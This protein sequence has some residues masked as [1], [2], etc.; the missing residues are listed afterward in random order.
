MLNNEAYS[1]GSITVYKIHTWIR[2]ISAIIFLLCVIPM[3]FVRWIVEEDIEAALIA[4]FILTMPVLIANTLSKLFFNTSV[5]AT[6]VIVFVN[7]FIAWIAANLL[8]APKIHNEPITKMVREM[9]KRS[10]EK[11]NQ[12][13][14]DYEERIRIKNQED[15]QAFEK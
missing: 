5:F 11:A 2:M 14:R 13:A 7:V 15:M 6:I 10:A 1:G 8:I 3:F 12:D 9:D 4:L